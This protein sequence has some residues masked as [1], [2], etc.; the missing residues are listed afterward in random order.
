LTSEEFAAWLTWRELEALPHR[1]RLLFPD[2]F[3]EVFLPAPAT[4]TLNPG[5]LV[6]VRLDRVTPREDQIKISL[7]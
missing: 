2:I 4:L 1:Y 6:L 5:D 7:A 3:L